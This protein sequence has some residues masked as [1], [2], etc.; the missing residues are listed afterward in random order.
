MDDSN[1]TME[2]YIK[3]E[4]EKARKHGKVFNWETA[5][6]GKIWYDEDIHDLRSVE[7]EF[8]AIAF[9]D[10][11]SSEKTLS[12]ESTVSSLNDEIDFRISFD[13]SDDEDY[14]P[15]FSCFDNLDF[16]KDFENEFP[17]IVYNDAQTSKSDLLTEPILIPQHIDEFDLNDETSLSEYDE[18]EQNVLYFNDLFPFN[19]IHPDDFKSEKDNDDNK[20]DIIQCSGDIALP[21]CDQRHQYLRYKGLQY[22]DVDIADFE[23][24]AGMLRG[25]AC[26]LA[27]LGGGFFDIRGPLFQLDGARRRLTWR[28]FIL[29]LGLHTNKEMQTIR[30]R[31]HISGGQFVA[32]LVEHFRLLT[33]KILQGL[34]IIAPELPIIDMVELVRLQICMEIDDTWAWVA[35]RP[36]RQ[37]DV[38]AG[39]PKAAEDAL[40]DDDDGQAIPAPIQA[41]QPPPPLVAARTMPQRLGRL[42]EE[43]QGLRR[44]VKSLRGLVERSMTDQGRFS[45][46]MISCIT[47]LMEASGQA[48]QT[49]DGTFRGSSPAAF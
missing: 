5:K 49:F 22:T 13:D 18:E 29:A 10:E 14:T 21:P 42:K 43:V 48:Y 31:A 32:R 45:T 36:E 4:E 38:A 12:C 6:Y 17:S 25:R 3:L 40:V 9:Y 24:S 20:I 15:T 46:W 33:V 8:P 11:V 44:D 27:E 28:Q 37:P 1:I 7:T 30:F 35:M 34:T 47:Q 41:P 26:L 19:I 39:A 16:F 23:S 2:E